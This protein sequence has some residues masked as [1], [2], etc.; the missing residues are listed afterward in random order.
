MAEIFQDE[1]AQLLYDNVSALVGKSGLI[2]I[3]TEIELQIYV[4]RFCDLI[5]TDWHEDGV[6]M[7]YQLDFVNEAGEQDF[8][9]FWHSRITEIQYPQSDVWKDRNVV[10]A[11]T[12]IFDDDEDLRINFFNDAVEDDGSLKYTYLINKDEKI[13]VYADNQINADNKFV[14]I[15]ISRGYLKRIKDIEDS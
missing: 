6:P 8:I 15:L 11:F 9:E 10:L 1:V 5:I 7:I 13:E 3:S 12:V 2:G 14:D 4:K